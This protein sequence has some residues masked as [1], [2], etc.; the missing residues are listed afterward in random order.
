MRYIKILESV[1]I[2][3][4]APDPHNHPIDHPPHF[5]PL[6]REWGGD[7]LIGCVWGRANN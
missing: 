2:F 4:L 3:K 7:P 6:G 1:N 5:L